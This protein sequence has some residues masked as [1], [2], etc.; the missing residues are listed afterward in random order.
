MCDS[1]NLTSSYIGHYRCGILVLLMSYI[2]LCQCSNFGHYY[3][4]FCNCQQLFNYTANLRTVK[5]CGNIL[6][7]EELNCFFSHFE[8][9]PPEPDT[10]IPPVINESFTVDK[11]V[12][13][14]VN[15]KKTA[16]PDGVTGR[17]LKEWYLACLFR[18][19]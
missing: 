3:V 7:G 6:L 11:H 2:L 10:T 17:I 4:Q 9:E 18:N 13:R 5:L 16:G 19:L 12:F 15:L 14:E 8:V 1:C